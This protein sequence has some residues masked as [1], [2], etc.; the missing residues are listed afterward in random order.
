MSPRPDSTELRN[1][2]RRPA[3]IAS[4]A[5]RLRRGL[6]LESGEALPPP[7]PRPLH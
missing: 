7:P 2:P 5:D 3:P 1:A 4:D 6:P